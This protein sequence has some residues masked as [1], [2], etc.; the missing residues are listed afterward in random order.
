M[1]HMPDGLEVDN[2]H[3]KTCDD[4]ACDAIISVGVVLELSLLIFT[5]TRLFNFV[6]DVPSPVQVY[7]CIKRKCIL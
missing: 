1:N 3:L 4:R 2:A 6:A 7:N 5:A